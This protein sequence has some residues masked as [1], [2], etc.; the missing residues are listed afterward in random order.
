MLYSEFV[1]GTGCK[2]NEYNYQVYRDLEILYMH[3]DKSHF[4]I[5]E[6]G[7]KLVDNGEPMNES[8]AGYISYEFKLAKY[9]AQRI[10]ESADEL[11]KLLGT[12]DN[13]YNN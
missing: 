6:M 10:R 4:E 1:T 12:I 8:D 9:H 3:S 5:Y 2:D 13:F 7:K 11:L